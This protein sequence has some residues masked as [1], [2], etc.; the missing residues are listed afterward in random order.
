MKKMTKFGT[1]VITN[2]PEPLHNLIVNFVEKLEDYYLEASEG[3]F[4]LQDVCVRDPDQ[5]ELIS[6]M[7]KLTIQNKDMNIDRDY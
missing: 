7:F 6:N 1:D 4:T 2:M 3:V 5:L